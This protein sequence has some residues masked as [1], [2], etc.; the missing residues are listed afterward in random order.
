M[1]KATFARLA[2]LAAGVTSGAAFAA[3]P[4]GVSDGLNT[5]KTDGLALVDAVWPVVIAIVGAVVVL[6]LF[7]RFVN[8]I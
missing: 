2:V 7:K 8:K 6:K 4:A 3:L 1:K 5:I